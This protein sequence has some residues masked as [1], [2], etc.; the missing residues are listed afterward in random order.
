M[1]TITNSLIAGLFLSS[2]FCFS[3]QTTNPLANTQ[4][5]G[6]ANVPTPAEVVFRFNTDDL[7]LLYQGNVIEKMKYSFTDQGTLKL[8]KIEGNS[9]CDSKDEG[10]YKYQIAN[11]TLTFII[12]N[13]NCGERQA[14]F[15]GNGYKKVVA[16]M[17]E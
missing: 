6:I 16:G 9:P 8:V 17:A 11:D 10:L 12:M 15:D 2:L 7:D 3:Q 5:K 4:W 14:A 13:D 1:K